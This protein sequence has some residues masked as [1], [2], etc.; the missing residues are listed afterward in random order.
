ML[1]VSEAALE[2]HNPVWVVRRDACGLEALRRG[3][4]IPF[5]VARQIFSVVWN[6]LCLGL[7]EQRRG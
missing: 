1:H 2:G 3:Q 5:Q 7:L 4:G 6:N